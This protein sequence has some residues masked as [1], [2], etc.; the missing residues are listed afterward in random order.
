MLY[1]LI[2]SVS[3]TRRPVILQKPFWLNFVR[4]LRLHLFRA[5]SSGGWLL[6]PVS[7]GASARRPSVQSQ[8]GAVQPGEHWCAARCSHSW[9]LSLALFRLLGIDVQLGGWHSFC[10]SATGLSCPS[11]TRLRSDVRRGHCFSACAV[12]WKCGSIR[13]DRRKHRYWDS[14]S[15]AS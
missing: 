12:P 5:C 11:S 6:R 15:S 4:S 2:H 9:R 7:R 10:P 13:E 8:T 1:E 3:H 14:G